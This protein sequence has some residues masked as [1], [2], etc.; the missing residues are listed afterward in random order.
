MK[1]TSR[2]VYS[3]KLYDAAGCQIDTGL[4]KS[5][6]TKSRV[7]VLYL[8]AIKNAA[9]LKINTVVRARDLR[10]PPQCFGPFRVITVKVTIPG[11]YAK[12]S[13]KRVK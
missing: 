6:D 3:V 12:I 10:R 8:R 2:N 9:P 5:Y 7:A 4:I 1:I 11:S 13:G